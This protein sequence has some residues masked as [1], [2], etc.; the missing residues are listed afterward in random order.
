M[1]TLLTLEDGLL[2]IIRRH[3]LYRANDLHNLGQDQNWHTD[4]LAQNTAYYP[5]YLY[6]LI[7]GRIRFTTHTTYTTQSW[8]RMR[9][10]VVRRALDYEKA[11]RV[12][13]VA[14]VVRWVWDFQEV[15]RVVWVVWGARWVREFEEVVRVLWVAWQ[16]LD[17]QS[18]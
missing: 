3:L 7:M 2:I 12:V 6:Y 8:L 14:W 1:L 5:Y 16:N 9:L 4:C 13:W 18:R 10:R 17:V 15:V 11:A